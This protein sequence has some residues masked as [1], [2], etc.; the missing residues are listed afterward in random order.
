MRTTHV[1]SVL[2]LILLSVPA[3]AAQGLEETVDA[4]MN[5]SGEPAP[6]GGVLGDA[7]NGTWQASCRFVSD[8]CNIVF[9]VCPLEAARA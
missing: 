1:L 2:S 5:C 4:R 9:G 3:V 8:L 7:V 6:F